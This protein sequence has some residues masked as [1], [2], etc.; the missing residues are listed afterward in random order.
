MSR[1]ARFLEW[2]RNKQWRDRDVIG[3]QI[4]TFATG[5]LL[6]FYWWGMP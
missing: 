3:L 6:G 5:L 1:L 2:R 4:G